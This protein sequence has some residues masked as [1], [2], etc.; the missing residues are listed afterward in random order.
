MNQERLNQI[1]H[2]MRIA[3]TD[4]DS[5]QRRIAFTEATNL[6]AQYRA[7]VA[8][9]ADVLAPEPQR[10]H[11]PVPP[12]GTHQL[13][14]LHPPILGNYLEPMVPPTRILTVPGVPTVAPQETTAQ[15][16]LDFSAAGGCDQGFLIGMHG[17]VR[18][19]TA[20]VQNAGFYEYASIELE[21]SFNDGEFLITNGEQASF[22]PYCDLFS[23]GQRTPFPIY[24]QVSS[25]DSMFFRWRNVQPA[26]T[27]NTLQPSLTFL[28][29][30]TP[31]RR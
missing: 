26:G 28:F 9:G 23:P 12:R 1:E 21:M 25:S 13:A 15:A 24:R 31:F 17:N 27:G 18:D 22:A 16:K 11:A 2:L 14:Q 4:P 29:V 5:T 8:R 20:G 19:D 6:L 7:E 30:R 3:G 10:M